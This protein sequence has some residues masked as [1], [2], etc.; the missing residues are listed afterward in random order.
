LDA[1]NVLFDFDT[2]LY[3]YKNEIFR[4][5]GSKLVIF[6]CPHPKLITGPLTD[7]K[8]RKINTLVVDDPKIQETVLKDMSFKNKIN[9]SS[10]P[11]FE[12]NIKTWFNNDF[13]IVTDPDTR[14]FSNFFLTLNK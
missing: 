9:F 6:Y 14:N 4:M 10:I 1:N 2:N 7:A 8:V 3:F 11:F 5:L 12:Q 13:S